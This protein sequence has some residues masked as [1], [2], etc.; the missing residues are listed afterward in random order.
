MIRF[1]KLVFVGLVILLAA[2][3]LYLVYYAAD[4]PEIEREKLAEL[5]E[6]SPQDSVNTASGVEPPPN[7]LPPAEPRQAVET[8]ET[9]Q[10]PAQPP[11]S[12][13]RRRPEP[14]SPSSRVAADEASLN[15]GEFDVAGAV[16]NLDSQADDGLS[17]TNPSQPLPRRRPQTNLQ[18][19]SVATAA[20]STG[21]TDYTIARTEDQS[22]GNVKRLIVRVM[23][24]EHYSQET[25]DSV[26]NAIVTRIT[27]AQK[28]NAVSMLFFGPGTSIDGP[29]DIANVDWAPNGNWSDADDVRS[30]EYVSFRYS[31]QY[32]PSAT[33]APEVETIGVSTERGLLGAPLPAGAILISQS[34]GDPAA[35]RDPS[36]R[37]EI[38]ASRDQ[39]RSFYLREMPKDGWLKDGPTD[40]SLFFRK[41]EQLLGV[42]MN[43]DSREF[44]LVGS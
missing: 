8:A 20:P 38:N 26:A 14:D 24:K 16:G 31:I 30:G 34:A 3:A 12:V 23:M 33:S 29:W 28:V 39:V 10:N 17:P 13:P 32:R 40:G 4:V 21:Q 35:L 27:A 37:Y 44:L 15:E 7:N 42:I 19:E 41:G 18:A 6:A 2:Q 11:Q 9:L 22:F 5:L 43:P 1:L 25:V 36:E